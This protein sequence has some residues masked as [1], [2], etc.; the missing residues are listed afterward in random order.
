MTMID[1]KPQQSF[2]STFGTIA[3]IQAST[4]LTRELIDDRK[5]RPDVT[6]ARAGLVHTRERAA[7][8]IES[9]HRCASETRRVCR[10]RLVVSHAAI[11]ML[12]AAA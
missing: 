3:I 8:F 2:K 12:S 5:S 1:R 7:Q 11:S 9:I 6:S 10:K 4:M